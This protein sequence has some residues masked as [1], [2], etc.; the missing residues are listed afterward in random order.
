MAQPPESLLP[1]LEAYLKE[2]AARLLRVE[3]SLVDPRQRM[4]AMGLDSLMAVELQHTI[5]TDLDVVM[6]MVSFLQEQSIA[7]LA[8][9][10]PCPVVI[11]V[12]AR[13]PA[14][15]GL[16]LADHVVVVA[17]AG[18]EAALAAAVEG[19]LAAAGHSVDI[20]VNRVEEGAARDLPPG[21]TGLPEARL[22]AQVA[23][24]CRGAHG[25]LAAPVAS[26]AARC[27]ARALR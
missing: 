6:P 27:T 13:A 24:A 9:E 10:R 26:I 8:A 20:V 15:D 16:G 18:S 4:S 2:Q 19:S 21:A 11:E 5:E 22:A 23:L 17:A 14:S 12:P 1:L 25:P 7:L 3:P